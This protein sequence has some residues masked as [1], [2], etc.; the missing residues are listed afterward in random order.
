MVSLFESNLEIN[1][2]VYSS[3]IIILFISIAETGESSLEYAD[4][5]Y[6]YGHALLSKEEE[7]PANSVLG[8]VEAPNKDNPPEDEDVD[9]DD[10]DGADDNAE[11]GAEGVG[12]EEFGEPDGD[13]QIAWECLDVARV[14]L[15]R[16]SSTYSKQ[17]S[18]VSQNLAR[19]HTRLFWFF[20][21]YH[22]FTVFYYRCMSA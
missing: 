13:V 6:W 22:C 7:N 18:N 9:D 17:L 12:D 10:A 21:S 14:I 2:H 16:Q 1:Y 15:E 19:I 3:T 20:I 8:N 11:E 4:I 5:M